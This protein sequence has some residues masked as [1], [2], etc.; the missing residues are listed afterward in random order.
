MADP[1]LTTKSDSVSQPSSSAL[2]FPSLFY[3]KELLPQCT[4]TTTTHPTSTFHPNRKQPPLPSVMD[5]VA[6]QVVNA[7]TGKEHFLLIDETTTTAREV[8]MILARDLFL[9]SRSGLLSAVNSSAPAMS[10]FDHFKRKA[11]LALLN[12]SPS[13]S[14]S[15]ATSSSTSGSSTSTSSGPNGFSSLNFA[16]Y[17]LSV[18]SN[19]SYSCSDPDNGLSADNLIVRSRRISDIAV[20]LW[21]KYSSNPFS[22]L[23][24]KQ[25]SSVTSSVGSDDVGDAE[26][27]LRE[28]LVTE[29]LRTHKLARKLNPSDL[30]M[31][32]SSITSSCLGLTQLDPIV[33]S[34]ELSSHAYCL[35]AN[36]DPQSILKHVLYS[37][38]S[39]KPPQPLSS[40]ASSSSTA[41][42]R[43]ELILS[44]WESLTEREMFWVINQI[45]RT[46]STPERVKV[47]KNLIKCALFCLYSL[48]NF[49]TAASITCA[50]GHSSVTRL[51]KT[52]WNP[53]EKK[54]KSLLK[55]LEKLNKVLDPSKNMAYY[56]TLLQ[57]FRELSTWNRLDV[58]Q[59]GV[60]NNTSE[61]RN[62]PIRS[63]SL[64]VSENTLHDK[65]MNS[66]P[67]ALKRES[68]SSSGTSSSAGTQVVIPFYPVHKKDFTFLHLTSETFS[69]KDSAGDGSGVRVNWNKIR[70]LV[71]AINDFLALGTSSITEV[72]QT[73]PL[74][75]SIDGDEG[76]NEIEFILTHSP[77]NPTAT[78]STPFVLRRDRRR[79]PWSEVTRDEKYTHPLLYK[80][81]ESREESAATSSSNNSNSEELAKKLHSFLM[82]ETRTRDFLKSH[83][84]SR[85]SILFNEE[86]LMKRSLDIESHPISVS[87]NSATST[88]TVS[89][90]TNNHTDQQNTQQSSSF[91][92]SSSSSTLK[93]KKD[94]LPVTTA[95]GASKSGE[96]SG[97]TAPDTPLELLNGNFHGILSGKNR[98]FGVTS[99]DQ[100]NK[101][102]ALQTRSAPSS[103]PSSNRSSGR[104][105]AGSSG[106]TG[107]T[108]SS[109]NAKSKSSSR[110]I[111]LELKMRPEESRLA[112]H[113]LYPVSSSSSSSSLSSNC[114]TGGFPSQMHGPLPLSH[115]ANAATLIPGQHVPGSGHVHPSNLHHCHNSHLN[116][117]G[118]RHHQNQSRPNRD[119]VDSLHHHMMERER[120][121]LDRESSSL[122][123]ALLYPIA[124]QPPP[125]IARNRPTSPLAVFRTKTKN[126]SN[127]RK[128]P[129][130]PPPGGRPALSILPSYEETI[131][132]LRALRTIDSSLGA[133]VPGRER[134][135]NG[136]QSSSNTRSRSTSC[137]RT[138]SSR[139][140]ENLV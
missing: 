115:A 105:S 46:D 137:P 9:Q 139:N 134:G 88:T 7:H 104:S 103:H 70:S 107:N 75:D 80:E 102:L 121:H 132:N 81:N 136:P 13:N 3:S 60:G 45:L 19:D 63:R 116:H 10:T 86:L 77:P 17:E 101:L 35:F 90:S 55:E 74:D 11:S 39:G 106:A 56:R 109:L 50:L 4:T 135:H 53:L 21:S 6:L 5:Q 83:F 76:D 124:P 28:E 79:Y 112:P 87:S 130:P 58:N 108:S 133:G 100:L 26:K 120:L 40:S 22:R 24:L 111:P 42:D 89:N 67:N 98:P 47:V 15:N 29:F 23:F 2:S 71:S 128:D 68:V 85:D 48:R 30:I 49:S 91:L 95:S 117:H 140:R 82:R 37:D 99:Y 73:L 66:G 129:A 27:K 62:E 84:L 65:G 12:H 113:A 118:H 125:S 97:K 122:G 96:A 92:S 138:P 44:L 110:D 126:S 51:R 93:K 94:P 72:E 1:H 131:A 123:P 31:S 38:G 61:A 16:L 52:L 8:V 25:I 33:L 36:L 127:S 59:Q 34:L 18:T 78:S 54:H 20:N 14:A 43:S 64:S 119:E 41:Q 114:I 32:P 57:E 69:S